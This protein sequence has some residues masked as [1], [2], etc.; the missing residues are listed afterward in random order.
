MEKVRYEIDPYNRLV[1][2]R[3]GRE[4]SLPLFRQVLDGEFKADKNNNLTYHIKAPV[5]RGIKAPYQVK[6][7]GK[8]A[9]D[10]NRDL[11][12][13][14]DKL[15]SQSS[16]DRL[17]IQGDIIDVRK[18][19]LLFAVTT[20]VNKDNLSAYILKLA[21]AWQADE[22]NRLTFRVNKEEGRT[23]I[24]TFEGVWKIGPGY[25][26]IYKY[27]KENLLRKTKRVHTLAFQGYWEI[28]DRAR[29]SY[30]IDRNSDSVMNFKTSLGIFKDNYIKYELG[31]GRL[32]K[33]RPVRRAI[34]LFGSW[35]IKKGIGLVFEVEYG[36]KRIQDMVFGA[37][38]RLTDKNTVLFRLKDGLNRKIGVEL[39]LTHQILGRDGQAYIRLLKSGQESAI[40]AGA[41]WRW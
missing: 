8:W 35:K 21:G 24:L 22:Y 13:T 18:N 27:E 1:S 41:G 38:A 3:R 19:S 11:T 10:K 25:Q 31:I 32:R 30:V 12:F 23:D 34:V 40:L 28:R 5:S 29:I 36:R 7:K 2:R 39:E 37:E 4:A 6:L 17:T 33:A 15:K 26:V 16:G 14:L 20:R 9:L